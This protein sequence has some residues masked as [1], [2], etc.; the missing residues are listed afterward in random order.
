MATNPAMPLYE[1]GK[2][3]SCRATA[4]V[5]GKR[6]VAISGNGV[7][8]NPSAAH[9]TAA[10]RVFGVSGYDV[11]SGDR[12]PVVRKGVVPV[13][14]GAALTA[15]QEVE[16]GAAGVAVVKAAGVAVGVVLF[17]A[18]NAADAYVDLY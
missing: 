10:G 6:F 9:A 5:T 4:N 8:P 12:F 16:V 13:T 17:D 1:Y 2:N 14:A 3:V 18:A 15:G 11:P 7:L